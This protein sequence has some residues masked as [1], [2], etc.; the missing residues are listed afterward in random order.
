MEIRAITD[1]E[2]TQFQG[3]LAKTAGISLSLAKKSL[4][5]SRLAKRLQHCRVVSYGEYFRLITSN[6]HKDEFLVALDLLTTNETYFFREPK[7]FDLLR[8]KIVPERKPG[9]QFRVW[10]AACSSGEE[11]YSIAMLLADKIGESGWE[12]V[13]SDISTRMLVKARAGHYSMDRISNVPREYLSRFCLKG[14]GSKNGTFLVDKRLRGKVEFSRVNLNEKL[15]DIGEFD[16]IF[17]RNVMIYF[18]LD[19]KREVVT[20]LAG[21]LRPGG[22]FI[23]GHSESLSGV[24][25]KLTAVAPS[26]YRK[27]KN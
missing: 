24:T 16:V 6:A 10:S 26:V 8:D 4:V 13:A 12:V 22:Y 1:Q 19:T 18:G 3:M 25:D 23:I 21:A 5:G 7:H 11:P 17:L 2:F 27:P 9:A 14:I 20:R 15:P